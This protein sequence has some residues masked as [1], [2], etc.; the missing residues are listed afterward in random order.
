[1]T[2]PL[3]A[4][5][6]LWPDIDGGIVQGSTDDAGA[7]VVF[8]SVDT[9]RNPERIARVLE[10]GYPL[11]IVVDEAH[12]S[13]SRTHRKAIDGLTNPDRHPYMLGLTATPERG[14]RGDLSAHWAVA[15]QY[16]I[17]RAIE[18]GY[19]VTPRIVL[20][21]ID[22]DLTDVGCRED[23]DE[24]ELGMAMLLAGIVAHT[25]RAMGEHV[26]GHTAL[27]FTCT[28]DQAT[29]TADALRAAG[30]RAAVVSGDTPQGKRDR[31]LEGVRDGAIDAVCNCAVLTE[32]TDLPIVDAV[33]IAR[34]T[35]VKPLY[36]QMVGRG[37]RLYPG[38]SECIVLDLAGASIE[39]SLIQAP[40]LL[41][42][43]CDHAWVEPGECSKCGKECRCWR[44]PTGAHDYPRGPKCR[45]CG[46]LQCPD[47]P[48]GFHAW[49]SEK[50]G[51]RGCNYCPVSVVDPLYGMISRREPPQAAQWL[52][53]KGGALVV[54]VGHHGLIILRPTGGKWEA[55]WYPKRAR[56]PRPLCSGSVS[57]DLAHGL[58]D[59]L[60]RR[61]APITKPSAE[62]RD[63][64]PSDKQLAY[65]DRLGCPVPSTAGEC[66]DFI[67][68]ARAR[69]LLS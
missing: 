26:P 60:I 22:V 6:A 66:S 19:L 34:P 31:I 12:H 23:Y 17:E 20:D 41:S 3:A 46:T 5:N 38:K 44:S 14:D 2:Q 24:A 48:G 9:L 4:L 58:A 37:L 7:Q 51:V 63:R 68:I 55:L 65:A 32:G 54:D 43:A 18:D 36:I 30:W 45:Y 10:H 50:P 47:A 56:K 28:V 57:L 40:V 13:T 33:V 42:D 1:L 61:A 25:V 15:Y 39:H 52:R 49:Y 11:L 59:D 64:A 69:R 62:W 29:Q 27:V 67:T 21:C 8:G 16:P 35:R 53:V